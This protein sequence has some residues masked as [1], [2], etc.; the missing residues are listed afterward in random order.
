MHVNS[1][2]TVQPQCNSIAWLVWKKQCDLIE[3]GLTYLS[4]MSRRR[5]FHKVFNVSACRHFSTHEAKRYFTFYPSLT[6][7][8]SYHPLPRMLMED[9]TQCHQGAPKLCIRQ[10]WGCMG[11]VLAWESHPSELIW[12]FTPTLCAS[13]TEDWCVCAVP[14]IHVVWWCVCLKY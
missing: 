6:H 9:A 3:H 14:Y 10:N 4:F 11:M 13:H 2:N 7:T 1:C 5:S 12:P 8:I